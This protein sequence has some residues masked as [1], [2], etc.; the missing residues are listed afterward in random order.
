MSNLG[1][2]QDLLKKLQTISEETAAETMC[3]I[4]NLPAKELV[5]LLSSS[6]QLQTLLENEIEVEK[7]KLEAED[8]DRI[9]DVKMDAYGVNRAKV[10]NLL[11]NFG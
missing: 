8:T 2:K 4:E 10:V 5:S 9:V 7:K 11:D 6:I 1:Y 3:R